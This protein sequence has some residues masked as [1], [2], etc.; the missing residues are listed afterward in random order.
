ME[1][2]SQYLPRADGGGGLNNGTDLLIRKT[3]PDASTFVTQQ[4]GA[5][6]ASTISIS[7]GN[8]HRTSAG[9]SGIASLLLCMISIL[10]LQ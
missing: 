9:Q 1:L 4:C 5:G 10:F 8:A 7:S 3:Y 6:Y 2:Y